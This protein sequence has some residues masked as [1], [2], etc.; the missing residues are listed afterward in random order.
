M[1]QFRFLAVEGFLLL[2]CSYRAAGVYCPLE[3][4]SGVGPECPGGHACPSGTAVPRKCLQGTWCPSGSGEAQVCPAGALCPAG[5]EVPEP[6]PAG[7]YCPL[8]HSTPISCPA[9]YMGSVDRSDTT[10]LETGCTKCPEVCSI[11]QYLKNIVTFTRSASPL[12]QASLKRHMR[13]PSS[14]LRLE[15]WLR[16]PLGCVLLQGHLHRPAW[17]DRVLDLQ[18]WICMP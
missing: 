6:C 5:S 18:P 17:D 4:A 3:G 13:P 11:H 14:P 8:D 12:P 15:N 16:M 2:P 1:K 10:S 9:G 7:S